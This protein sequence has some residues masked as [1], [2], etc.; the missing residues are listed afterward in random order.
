[1]S[2][3]F[4]KFWNN[5]A[6]EMGEC[7]E[8]LHQVK[9]VLTVLGYMTK[10]SVA[11]IKTAKRIEKL[12]GEYTKMR[13][14]KPNE[15]FDRFPELKQIDAFTPGIKSIIMDVTTH[16]NRI[17]NPKCSEKE[18]KSTKTRVLEQVKKIC[19]QM[20][21]GN[22]MIEETSS[23]ATCKV[24]C[25]QCQTVSALGSFTNQT[26]GK[27]TFS[28]H[29]FTRHYTTMH[30]TLTAERGSHQT[31]THDNA[32][33][34][35]NPLQT[36]NQEVLEPTEKSETLKNE[37]EDWEKEIETKDIAIHEI[38]EKLNSALAENK[39]LIFEL[40]ALKLVN[41][42]LG[43]DEDWNSDL[44][45]KAAE[46][47]NLK[48]QL[49]S[50]QIQNQQLTLDK[51]DLE[52]KYND[53]VKKYTLKVAHI[54]TLEKEISTFRQKKI[55]KAPFV[56]NLCYFESINSDPSIVFEDNQVKFT[57]CQNRATQ[58]Y[59]DHIYRGDATDEKFK[60]LQPYLNEFISGKT[61]CV[62]N[63]GTTG[64][65]KTCTMFGFNG[66]G[67]ILSRSVGFILNKKSPLVVSVIEMTEKN[68]YDL[69]N[70]KQ[71]HIADAI[72]KISI[73]SMVDFNQLQ[74]KV[75][76]IRSQKSTDQNTTSSR[77][78]LIF[79]LSF[80]ASSAK[81]AFI[82][83][84]GWENAANTNIDESKFIN[85]SLTSLNT[86]LFAIAQQK[87]ITFDSNLTKL[88]KPYFSKGYKCILMY[89]VSKV[90][91]KKGLENIKKV[92]AS[93]QSGIAIPKSRSTKAIPEKKRKALESIENVLMN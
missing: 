80:E 77:S 78:H 66:S 29:N 81:I 46:I 8:D 63:H 87:V 21:D 9:S 64:S 19:E 27:Q 53:V 54:Q 75:L 72:T 82:D 16:M 52:Y 93:F 18:I 68:S 11:S 37:R 38:K 57:D 50:A 25:P 42:Q 76:K 3:M 15:I 30:V 41:G 24:S 44:N 58:L 92:V 45:L 23:G 91:M 1:M 89:H 48:K 43:N 2:G 71:M 39:K 4:P 26:T 90:A 65:G 60:D 28:I 20:T 32:H 22:I 79:E 36:A 6:E 33:E 31:D 74:L 47:E 59:F 34:K 12:E 17:Q 49:S 14:N 62:F 70:G 73:G 13:T 40:N 86:L 10:M 51:K 88:L 84:A 85:A 69:G 7:D 61:I 5:V 67:G 55:A 56:A 35:L 83:L